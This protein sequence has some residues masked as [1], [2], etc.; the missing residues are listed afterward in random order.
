MLKGETIEKYSVHV[1][2]KYLAFAEELSIQP[3]FEV[4]LSLIGTSDKYIVV[5]PDY[6]DTIEELY[7]R[8][9]RNQIL[10]PGLV[11]ENIMTNPEDFLAPSFDIL[12][13]AG[14]WN[15]SPF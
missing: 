3:P 15:E 4:F 9:D 12:W 13:Q 6:Y 2:K 5:D 1:L 7:K 14:G 11:L 8:F 10:L